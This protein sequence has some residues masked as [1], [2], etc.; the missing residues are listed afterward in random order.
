MELLASWLVRQPLHIALVGLV[1]L[2][3]WLRL[4]AT[5]LRDSPKGNLLWLP[6][7]LWLAYA[8]WEWLVATATPDAD[9]RVDLLLIW[10]ILGLATLWAAL[11]AVIDGWRQRRSA[12]P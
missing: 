5:L 8:A 10:P 11:R 3:L 6:A 12:G 1:H 4:R 7:L 9:I 2:G